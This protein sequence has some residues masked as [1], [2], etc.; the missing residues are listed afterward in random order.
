MFQCVVVRRGKLAVS[1]AA[2][3]LIKYFC[4]PLIVALGYGALPPK[5]SL[6]ALKV[7]SL[8]R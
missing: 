1:I 3:F 6:S 8:L 4:D 5:E 7:L 2:L